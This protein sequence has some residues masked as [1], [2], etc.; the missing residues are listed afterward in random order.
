[1]PVG[2]NNSLPS[3]SLILGIL[4]DDENK[5][6]MLVDT[7]AAMN[8]GNCRFHMFVMSQCPDIVDEFLQYGKDTAYDDVILLA[9][10]DLDDVDT[11]ANY[12]QMIAVI[13]Y[14]TPYIVAGKGPILSFALGNDVSLRG[15]LGLPTL[16][17]MGADIN[18]VKVY[19]HVLNL[20]VVFLSTYNLRIKVYPKALLSIITHTLF[21]L[22]FPL[23]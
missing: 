10:L 8:M 19:C 6:R 1:M 12:G 22:Q 17:A 14:K 15:V 4:E 21:L 7:G 16:L 2:I 9:T 11:D 5:V 23:T 20:I 13:R 18:L 3:V